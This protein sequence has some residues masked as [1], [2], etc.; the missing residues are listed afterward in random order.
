MKK[1]D[2][3]LEGILKLL[4]GVKPLSNPGYWEDIRE[5]FIIIIIIYLPLY[6]NSLKKENKKINNNNNNNNIL[7]QVVRRGDLKKPPG[8]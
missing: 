3:K 2:E 4:Q 7:Q 1:M 6:Y 5:Y 8:L